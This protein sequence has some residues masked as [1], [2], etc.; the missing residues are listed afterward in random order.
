MGLARIH[1][2]Y[3]RQIREMVGEARYE[4]N[5]PRFE[6]LLGRFAALTERKALTPES[7]RQARELR[8]QLAAEKHAFYHELGIDLPQVIQM[9]GDAIRRAREIVEDSLHRELEMPPVD[10]PEPEPTDN[11]WS[12]RFPPYAG[13]WSAIVSS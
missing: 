10:V 4:E 11:P 12:W 8:R 13:Q 5:L 2:R 7:N 3:G 6:E 9:R 1:E